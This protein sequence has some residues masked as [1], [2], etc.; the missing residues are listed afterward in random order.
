MNSEA[1][2]SDASQYG[3]KRPENVPPAYKPFQKVQVAW[4]RPWEIGDDMTGISVSE[5]DRM[6]GSPKPG[7]MIAINPSCPTDRWLVDAGYFEENFE[8]L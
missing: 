6:Y 3:T 5:V 4:M 2:Y 7:D 1:S 8:A